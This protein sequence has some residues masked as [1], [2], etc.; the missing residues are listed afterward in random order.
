MI[1]CQLPLPLQL[2]HPNVVSG[3]GTGALSAVENASASTCR[4]TLGAM[5]P[6]YHSLQGGLSAAEPT[7]AA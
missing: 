3:I 5:M 2:E 1:S 6:S 7:G 4:V